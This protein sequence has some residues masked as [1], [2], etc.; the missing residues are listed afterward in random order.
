LELEPKV[1]PDNLGLIKHQKNTNEGFY[2]KE[3]FLVV[4]P[5]DSL[6][7]DINRV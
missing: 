2:E 6:E 5:V 3:L 7:R 1:N 4:V